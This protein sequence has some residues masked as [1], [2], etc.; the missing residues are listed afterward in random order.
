[1]QQRREWDTW[2]ALG[3]DLKPPEGLRPCALRPVLAPEL[4]VN[5]YPVASPPRLLFFLPQFSPPH[6]VAWLCTHAAQLPC[7]HWSISL[8]PCPEAIAT[9]R[10][11]SAFGFPLGTHA[12]LLAQVPSPED[13]REDAFPTVC[14]LGGGPQAE[15]MLL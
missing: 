3:G 12:S 11:T 15:E 6:P 5:S 9:T 14:V 1:M 4:H 8:Q 13:P 10:Q 7:K 2:G